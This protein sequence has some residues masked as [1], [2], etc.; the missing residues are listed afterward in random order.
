MLQRLLAERLHL[1]AHFEKRELPAYVLLNGKRPPKLRK[2]G[3]LAIGDDLTI[4]GSVIGGGEIKRKE[5]DHARA[6]RPPIVRATYSGGRWNR[7][8]GRVRSCSELE[9][10]CQFWCGRGRRSARRIHCDRSA[11]RNRPYPK[12]TEGSGRLSGRR[13][14]RESPTEN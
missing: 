2:A 11:A 4:E 12:E 14:R 10:G 6:G 9:T 5:R 7:N 13:P 3:A 8:Q 1:Q